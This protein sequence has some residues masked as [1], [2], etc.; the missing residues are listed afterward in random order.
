MLGITD[1]LWRLLPGNPILLRVVAMAS[2]RKRDWFVR[3]G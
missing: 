2:K 3:M 1:Y